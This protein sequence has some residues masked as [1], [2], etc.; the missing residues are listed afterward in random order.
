MLAAPTSAMCVKP[1]RSLLQLAHPCAIIAV[2]GTIWLQRAPLP[3]Q[4]ARLGGTSIRWALLNR[5]AQ[6][7]VQLADMRPALLQHAQ[8]AVLA[9]TAGLLKPHPA[10]HAA[11][12]SPPPLK[13]PRVQTVC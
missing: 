6:A 3:V 4:L 12:G 5:S 9:T 8:C 1:A 7:F 13:A 11:L 10:V 2:L